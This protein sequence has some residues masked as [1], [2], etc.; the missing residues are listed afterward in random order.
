MGA[1]AERRPPSGVA[2][3]RSAASFMDGCVAVAVAEAEAVAVAVAEA[4]AVAVAVLF[5]VCTTHIFPVYTIHIF[6]VHKVHI[7]PVHT[8]HIFPIWGHP[9]V[10]SGSLFQTVFSTFSDFVR[11]CS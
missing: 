7:F 2:A 4:V 9:G 11:G 3:A 6:P 10:T 8:I 1:G 5:P